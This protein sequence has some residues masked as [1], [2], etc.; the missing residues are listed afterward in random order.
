MPYT[1]LKEFLDDH[2]IKY[3][4]ISHSPAYTAQEIA[5]SAHIAG[6]EMAK[7]VIVKIDGEMKMIVLPATDKVDFDAVKHFTKAN[8][9]E[10]ASE[11]EF[12]SRFPGCE[13]GAM[14][15]FGNLFG[16][17]VFI[18]DSLT[19]NH[20]IAFNA[21]THTELIRLSYD[22]YKNLAKPTLLK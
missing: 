12:N 17:D 20:E 16:M 19:K 14:P 2:K 18:E 13:L 4:T 10:L 1:K 8:K 6:R 21:G 15:P 3:I 22:D 11:Y 5:Q 9:V 7:T